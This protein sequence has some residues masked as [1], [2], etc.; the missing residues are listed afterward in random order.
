MCWSVLPAPLYLARKA[1]VCFASSYPPIRTIWYSRF[2]QESLG[3][4]LHPSALGESN[5][6]QWYDLKIVRVMP[7]LFGPSI[8]FPLLVV[9]RWNTGLR[10][11]STILLLKYCKRISKLLRCLLSLC[12]PVDLP[13]LQSLQGVV[14]L[15]MWGLHLKSEPQLV[16]TWTVNSATCNF[17]VIVWVWEHCPVVR[18]SVPFANPGYFLFQS[19]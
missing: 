6:K 3:K 7:W 16:L 2:G 4:Q 14:R 11:R 9:N 17:D 12:W 1:I 8:A 15:A 19:F 5:W 13:V 10:K 18:V